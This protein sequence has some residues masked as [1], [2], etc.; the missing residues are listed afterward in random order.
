VVEKI[1]YQA[2]VGTLVGKRLAASV[3]QHVRV[4]VL[5]WDKSGS[6]PLGRGSIAM[7]PG[8]RGDGL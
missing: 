8:H 3:A 6:Y 5:K 7:P 4:H 1:L 2:E